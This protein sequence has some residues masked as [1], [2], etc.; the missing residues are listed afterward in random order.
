VTAG[1]RAG[2]TVARA[3]VRV[4]S[5]R[6]EAA[7]TLLSD[8]YTATFLPE[9]GMLGVSC[10]HDGDELVALPRSLAEHRRS[11]PKGGFTGLPLNAPYANRLSQRAFVVGGR[12]A[13]VGRSVPCDG[14]RLPIHGTLHAAPF[15]VDHLGHAGDTATARAWFRHDDPGL[16]AVFPFEHTVT[17]DV[18]L[19]PRGLRVATTIST[20]E[21][22][23]VPV[24]F[25]WH[26]FLR[27]PAT[28][29]AQWQLRLPARRHLELDERLIPTGGEARE[30]VDDAAL[31]GR[32]FD[33]HYR[34]GRDRRFELRGV[35]R[36][37]EIRFDAGYPYAQ[38]Y[39]PAADATTGDGGRCDYVCI[40]P[41]TAPIDALVTG[42]HPVATRD[43]PYAAG[44][45]LAAR[46]TRRPPGH[47]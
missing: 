44:F 41:M 40:E 11:M 27:V 14:Q 30:P 4:H 24:S 42:R 32:T 7:V 35:D 17:I 18:E 5:W 22:I 34:L 29:R 25:G 37:I 8:A 19:S 10:T 46:A 26:P 6:G 3:G 39:V 23:A 20:D 15:V 45:T 36:R 9:V 43:A 12:H 13:V 21:R 16:L 31:G 38:I 33:D 1:A 2:R 28:P 47:H